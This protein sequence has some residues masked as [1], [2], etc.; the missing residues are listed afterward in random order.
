MGPCK[1]ITFRNI[2]PAL[3]FIVT[4]NLSY[5]VLRGPT[6]NAILPYG[7]LWNAM[8]LAFPL[9]HVIEVSER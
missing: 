4:L 7:H 2:L 6:R 9:T 5:L 8:F 1:V 3:V